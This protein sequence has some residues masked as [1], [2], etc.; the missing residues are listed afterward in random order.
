MAVLTLAELTAA[1]DVLTDMRKPKPSKYRGTRPP[2]PLPLVEIGD[3]G[4]Y[5]E[6]ILDT[7]A[8]IHM[9]V[10]SL[11]TVSSRREFIGD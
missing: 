4:I 2:G 1:S 8:D 9:R 5:L 6:D 10:N 11:E 3:R 7:L